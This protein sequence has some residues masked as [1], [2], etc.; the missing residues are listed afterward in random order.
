MKKVVMAV[1]LMAGIAGVAQEKEV[2]PEGGHRP[3]MEKVT[4]EEQTKQLTKELGLDAG[5]QAK[6]KELYAQQEKQRAANKPAEGEK[7][8]HAAMEEKMKEENVAFEGKIKA[9]LTADQY[10]KG[11][12][13]V[14]NKKGPKHGGG[15]KPRE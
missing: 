8:D 9:I 6:V 3:K 14:K 7:H 4:P 15:I 11:Q 10:T 5:Q 12:A 2:K 13:S 1:L